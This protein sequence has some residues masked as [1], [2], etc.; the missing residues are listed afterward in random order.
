MATRASLRCA[1][2]NALSV[3]RLT[4]GVN[5]RTGQGKARCVVIESKVDRLGLSIGR[6]RDKHKKHEQKGWNQPSN[7]DFIVRNPSHAA[8]CL[9][10]LMLLGR[11]RAMPTT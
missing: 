2:K 10:N 9:Q 4:G 5:V 11:I 7:H 1:A 6:A 8:P 3:A